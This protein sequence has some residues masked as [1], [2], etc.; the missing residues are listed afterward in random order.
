MKKLGFLFLLIISLFMFIGCKNDNNEPSEGDFNILINDYIGLNNTYDLKAVDKDG[1]ELNV[2]WSLDDESVATIEGDKITTIDIGIIEISA[3]YKGKVVTKIVV[4]EESKKIKYELNGGTCDGLQEEVFK[5]QTYVLPTPVKSGYV[6]EGWYSNSAFSGTPVTEINSKNFN[7]TS[8]Y[9]LWHSE[10]Y[11][12]KYVLTRDGVEEESKEDDLFNEDYNLSTPTYDTSTHVFSGWYLD[13]NLYKKIDKV[14][15]GT[16]TDIT[17]YGI[18]QNKNTDIEINYVASNATFPG[19]KNKETKKVGA[20]EFLS[21]SRTNYNFLGWYKD[22]KYEY[23]VDGA[24]YKSCS[25]YAKFSETYPVTSIDITNAETE[26]FRKLTLQLTYQLEPSVVSESGVI[27]TSSD[28]SIATISTS[29]LITAINKGTVTITIKSKS[30]SGASASITMDVVDNEY[31][32]VSYDTNSYVE[33][34]KTIKLNA[35]YNGRVETIT[36]LNWSSADTNV[37]SVEN[38]IV[39]GVAKG[40]TTIKAALK[41]DASKYYEFGVTVV[42]GSTSDALKYVLD[43]H[44]SNIFTRYNLGIGAGTPAYYMDIIGSVSDILYNY[45]YT[46]NTEFEK[47]QASI[48]SNHGGKKTC[49]EFIT[50]HYTG[51]MAAG[52]TARANASYFANGGSG[53]SIHYVTGNDGVFHCLD[54]DLIGFHAGDKTGEASEAA[55]YKTGVKVKEGDSIYP[56]WGISENSKYTLNG[57]ETLISVPKGDTIQTERVTDSRWINKMGFAYKIIDGEYYMGK[58]WWCYSQIS[59]GRLCNKGGNMN[60]VGI[61]SAVNKGTDLWLT[62]QITAMLVARLMVKYDLP[63]Q[64]VVG[65]HFYSAKDCPQPHLANNLE[66]WWEFIDLVLAEYERITTFSNYKFDMQV[67]SGSAD[68]NGRVTD[69]NEFKTITYKVVVTKPDNTKEEIILS[70]IIKGQFAL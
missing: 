15:A 36:D 5:N 17:V 48:D 14:E 10:K 33:V 13:K 20:S 49:T 67:L 63:I 55:W 4:I 46:V 37:A 57:E 34:G 39:T 35:S 18:V 40:A 25:L 44:N 59:E 64:R 22:S 26:L 60:S 61:E 41:N 1:K 29:G 3:S 70:S 54:D 11:E 32:S 12:I 45:N 16:K 69:G 9:A 65:H 47:V 53:T 24:I 50:V 27:F 68:T 58:T 52:A 56:T 21:P 23:P 30:E 6:F 62:W 2:T 66:I 19:G 42:D 43:S 38:G 28:S 8:L 31:F 51:N 7:I